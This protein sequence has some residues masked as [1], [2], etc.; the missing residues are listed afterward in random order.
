L[1]AIFV[2]QQSSGV[3]AR[4]YCALHNIH[5]KTFCAR[6]SVMKKAQSSSLVIYRLG[7][8]GK[9]LQMTPH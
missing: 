9:Y 6:K 7:N 3:A 5:F 2:A 4:E 8:V 1:K